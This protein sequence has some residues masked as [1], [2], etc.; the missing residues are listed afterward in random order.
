MNKIQT[1]S[2]KNGI[3]NKT[4]WIFKFMIAFT[5][6]YFLII[7]LTIPMIVIGTIGLVENNCPIQ[8]GWIPK[9]LIVMGS[10]L[11]FKLLINIILNLIILR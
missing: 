11:F 10:V 1:K 4:R 9:W 5:G 7:S 8:K 3:N 6:F 2:E